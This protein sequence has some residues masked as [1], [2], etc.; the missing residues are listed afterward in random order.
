MAEATTMRN[1]IRAAVQAEFM[2]IHIEGHNRILIQA[3]KRKI[4][5]PWE[6]KV[7]IH[8]ITTFLDR[9]NN[10]IINHTFR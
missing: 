2:D 5:V 4:Q 3:L 7:L 6:I 10:V 9:F 1:G 8:H